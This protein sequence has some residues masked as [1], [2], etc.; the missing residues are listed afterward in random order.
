MVVSSNGFPNNFKCTRS[1]R[2]RHPSSNRIYA[3]SNPAVCTTFNMS[4]PYDIL[5]TPK[6]KACENYESI[7][8][9]PTSSSA[10]ACT[11]CGHGPLDHKSKFN[12]LKRAHKRNQK[13]S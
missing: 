7:E 8:R 12:V 1:L 9:N 11:W 13:K 2:D 6:S 3:G 10:A 4:S 5:R